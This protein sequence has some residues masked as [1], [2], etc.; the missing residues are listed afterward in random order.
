MSAEPLPLPGIPE[1]FIQLQSMRSRVNEIIVYSV[2]GLVMLGVLAFGA[3]E[4]WSTSILEISIAL[5]AGLWAISQIRRGALIATSSQ[6]FLPLS[7][8]IGVIALQL[9]AGASSYRYATSSGLMLYLA[10]GCACFLITQT[11][12]RTTEVRRLATGLTT[13]GVSLAIF[14]VLQS[15]TFNGKIYWV[16]TPRFGGWVYGPYVNHNHYAGLMEMLAPIPLVFAFSKY[17]HGRTRWVAAAAA[18]FMGA[19]IFLSGSRGGMAAYALQVALF[20]WFLFRERTRNGAALVL[21]AF[22]LIAL[23]SVAWIGGSEV[24]DRISTVASHKTT[25]LRSDIRFSIYRDS[26]HLFLEHPI[27]GSG[28]GTFPHVYPAFRSFY[29]SQ[30]VNHAHNDYLELLTDTGLLG[31]GAG[32]WF[33]VT[34]VRRAVRKARTWSADV[35]GAVALAALIG[36]S[37]ILVHSL[38]DF[39]LQIPANAMLF[40]VLGAIGA[41]DTHFRNRRREHRHPSTVE[42]HSGDSTP[43]I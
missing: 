7:A 13:F 37:G 42:V 21:S 25:D 29:T 24:T 22:L 30:T 19:T 34:A 31:F 26:L 6:T 23:A 38:V 2:V 40:Y 17:A 28:L 16:R 18:A 10:Y 9:A 36:I 32:M 20:F 4:I 1:T 14:A 35:N 43:A 12:T 39:N 8:F 11:L 33:V 15:L 27:L 3:V 41:M 5:L